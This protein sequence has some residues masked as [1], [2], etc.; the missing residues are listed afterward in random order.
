[1][2]ISLKMNQDIFHMRMEQL[3]D[4]LPRI[5]TIHDDICIF[6]SNLQTHDQNVFKVN[7]DS[8]SAPSGSTKSY[9]M[10]QFITQHGI[11]PDSL[12]VQALQD[13]PTPSSQ[14]ELK[15]FLGLINYLQPSSEHRYPIGIGIPQLTQTSS[16][17]MHRPATDSFTQPLLITTEKNL[18]LYRLMTVSME[19]VQH[20]NNMAAQ[21]HCQ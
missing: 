16:S 17:K 12:K 11:R 18:S 9:F 21:Y 15:S 6:R 13:L 4:R 14:K 2:P 20:Y 7:E 19:W 1:M 8:R 5:I 3:T 10:G